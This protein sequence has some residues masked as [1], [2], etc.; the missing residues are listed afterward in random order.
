[1]VVDFSC[2][3]EDIQTA[4]LSCTLD[5]PCP[6]YL[7]LAAVE[8]VGN[9]IFLTGNIHSASTTLYSILLS[10]GDMGKTWREPYERIRS[11]GLDRIQFID[12][13]NGWASGEVLHPL[14]RDP[15]FL[16]TSDGGKAWHAYPIFSDPEFGS[17]LQFRFTSR[18]S[19]TMLVDRGERGE[20]GRYELYE[21]LTAGESWI[22]RATNEKPI[23][24]KHSATPESDWR[25]RADAAS[26]AYRVEHKTSGR[27]QGLAGFAVSLA[28]C[29]PPEA[30][31]ASNGGVTPG[32]AAD[33]RDGR[34]LGSQ[35]R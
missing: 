16:I 21:T 12:F 28:A 13:E 15:F 33:A 9:R 19:G 24:I 5:D 4:G 10:S 22:L 2:S 31:A 29:R 23:P 35:G 3:G 34:S 30:P 8:A 25:I 7:E 14:P 20:G 11:A 32:G 27:W 26:K 6:I 17:I 18:T 1:M